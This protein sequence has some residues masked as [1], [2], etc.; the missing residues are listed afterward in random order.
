[1]TANKPGPEQRRAQPQPQPQTVQTPRTSPPRTAG[2][3]NAEPRYFEGSVTKIGRD[4]NEV[5]SDHL[6]PGEKLRREVTDR[7]TAIRDD[8]RTD[9]DQE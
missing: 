1:M 2:D 5:L 9:A 6:L 4:G 8:K 3:E 7:Y